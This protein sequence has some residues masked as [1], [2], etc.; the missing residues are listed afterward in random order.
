M[1]CNPHG[2]CA[3]AHRLLLGT[4]TAPCRCA[5]G[6]PCAP[7]RTS[8]LALILTLKKLVIAGKIPGPSLMKANLPALKRPL[9]RRLPRGGRAREVV[10]EAKP[11][12]DGFGGRI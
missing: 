12:L 11:R 6:L 8:F 5:C 7:D 3:G 10:E 4:S 9:K 1:E 2:E